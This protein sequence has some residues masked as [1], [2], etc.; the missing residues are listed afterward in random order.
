LFVKVGAKRRGGADRVIEFIDPKSPLAKNITK[1]YWVKEDREKP[2]FLPSEVINKVKKADFKN[3]GM[4]QHTQFWKKHDGKN[5]DKGFGVLISKQWY[6]YEN[7][8]AF[9]IRSQKDG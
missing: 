4:H 9:V 6:W 2:K 3:F 1:E 5:P 8:I 7:W